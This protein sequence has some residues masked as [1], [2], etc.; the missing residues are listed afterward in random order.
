MNDLFFLLLGIGALVVV[1]LFRM[2]HSPVLRS[3]S[4]AMAILAVTALAQWGVGL[5]RHAGRWHLI[6]NVVLLLALGYVIAR[7]AL[8]LLF[9]VLLHR[10]VGLQVPRLARDVI[11]LVVY[12]LVCF[13]ILHS[14]LGFELS[15]LVATSAVVTVVIGLALQET[16]GTL[17]AGL[18]L[19]SERRLHTGTWVEIDGVMGEVEELGWRSL[20]LR[21]TTG[22]RVLLPNAS[23]ARTRIKVLGEGH[24][25]IALRIQVQVSYDA[26]P[27]VVREVLLR[28]ASD[29]PE[30][31]AE[32]APRVGVWELAESGVTYDCRLWTRCPWRDHYLKD[33]FL[34]RALAALKREGLELPYPQRTVH[35]APR[36]VGQPATSRV[37]TA[38]AG[39][40]LFAGLPEDAVEALVA[41]SRLQTYF[42]QESV[43]RQGEASQALYVIADG[44][45]AVE[46]DGK[47]LA[48]IHPGEVFGEM[49]FLSGEPRTATV[50][51]FSVLTLVEV[52]ARAL[53]ALLACS[54]ELA[55]ELAARMASRQQE[56]AAQ[57]E[58]ARAASGQVSLVGVLRER[59][60]RFLAG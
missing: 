35:L 27:P 39:C 7:S 38:L 22:E 17:L 47:T 41:A 55:G 40:P 52:D 16:L 25:P 36:T 34:S 42:P 28:A 58:L 12:F 24:D 57:A 49:A 31:L 11:A 20:V 56:L 30:V 45:A 48:S 10:H 3:L 21:T 60:Q 2:V 51:A 4:G 26:P 1:A 37:A 9:E 6:A 32:P 44:E 13:G 43:V 33:A 50:R 29:I 14:V 8:V 46:V 19:T 15:A 18:T 5:I 59:L 54:P 53:R 23:A